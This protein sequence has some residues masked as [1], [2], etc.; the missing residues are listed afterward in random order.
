MGQTISRYAVLSRHFA[1]TVASV[2][3]GKALLSIWGVFFVWLASR[4]PRRKNKSGRKKA[5]KR[6]SGGHITWL[7]KRL[8][9]SPRFLRN[10]GPALV[11][12]VLS[13]V[14][15]ILVTVKLTDAVGA[16]GSLL[17]SRDFEAMFKGQAWFGLLC[18]LAA[19]QTA[20]MK[21]LNRVVTQ[22]VRD[23]VHHELQEKYLARGKAD[24]GELLPFH[25]L[26]DAFDDAPARLT[27]DVKQLADRGV[28]VL[29]HVLKPCI[30]IAYVSAQ[31]GMRMGV[32]FSR[33]LLPRIVRL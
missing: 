20:I 21:F 28:H 10:A 9:N 3:H 29:G 27:A 33:L 8:L 11:A 23:E 14:T 5:K 1:G 15:R 4:K 31:L 22:R 24:G 7:L 25:A 17:A 26:G 18:C 19:L 16:T 13:L 12:Y 6:H 2:P 32:G 30:D